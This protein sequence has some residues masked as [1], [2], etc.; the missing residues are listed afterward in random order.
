MTIRLKTAFFIFLAF[1]ILGFL[2]LDRTILSPFILGAIFAYIFNPVVDFFYHRV[3]LPRTISIVIIYLIMVIAIVLTGFILSRRIISEASELKGFIDNLPVI[4]K[5]QIDTLP[6]WFR[7]TVDQTFLS[8]EKSKLFSSQS[9]FELFPQALSRIVSFLIFAFSG[10]YF[11]KDGRNLL[12]KLL[13]LV[14]ARHRPDAEMLGRKI[15]SAFAGYLRGQLFLVLIV[16]LILYVALSIL[17]VRF[18][19]ILALFSSFA[20]IIPLVGPITAG[21]VASLVVLITGQVNFGLTPLQGVIAAVV[22]YTAIRLFQ[23]YFITPHVMGR[24]TAIH[25][26]LIFFVVVSGGHL[27]GLLGYILA[28][29]V[30]AAIKILLEFSL[31]RLNTKNVPGRK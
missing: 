19:L 5:S 10:F 9:L 28:V 3:R 8:L 20:E 31:D 17:G 25:P 15:N 22:V 30:A 12:E 29:P 7:P 18:A 2:Y 23:D 27:F 1:L 16:A 14:P 21:A 26:F 4:L 24:I 11:L 13:N 6:D